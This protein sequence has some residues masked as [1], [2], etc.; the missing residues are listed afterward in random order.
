MTLCI[1]IPCLGAWNVQKRYRQQHDANVFA[2]RGG[3]AAFDFPVDPK[4]LLFPD[5]PCGNTIDLVGRFCLA[6]DAMAYAWRGSLTRL[7]SAQS[8]RF[9]H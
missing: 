5:A 7:R 9:G 1:Q 2:T 8:E 6:T 4:T 3:A